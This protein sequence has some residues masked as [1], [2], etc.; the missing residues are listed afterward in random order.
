MNSK[1]VV[2]KPSLG[3][4]VLCV[5]ALVGCGEKS[6]NSPSVSSRQ[7]AKQTPVAKAPAG[8][9]AKA[10]DGT[11]DAT[12]DR[13][14]ASANDKKTEPVLALAGNAPEQS[15]ETSSGS[16]LE[17]QWS[18]FL[19]TASNHYGFNADQTA[20][21]RAIY[22]QTTSAAEARRRRYEAKGG[23]NAAAELKRDLSRLRDQFIDRIDSIA[24]AEQ[25]NKAAKEGFKSPRWREPPTP[26]EVGFKAPDWSLRDPQGKTV[27]LKGLNGKVVVLKFWGS[28]CG[29]CKS[30]LPGFQKLA[31]QYED[32]AD[33][34]VIGVS[35]E[36]GRGP[37]KA[38]DLV[39]KQKYTFDVLVNGEQ[40]AALYQV[41]GFPTLF[42][43]GPDGKILHKIRGANPNVEKI[44]TPIIDRALKKDAA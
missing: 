44:L 36:R 27:S 15:N 21:A 28:W 6:N 34:E 8:A 38:L 31:E 1:R 11:P 12:T 14:P 29:A 33:V 16:D 25:I 37:E 35:C 43:I 18:A 26:P 4:S 13:K 9:T 7:E 3:V 23:P 32:N 22:N 24:S 41:T 20:K 30:A 42:V 39:K 40:I 5:S 10:P 2:R 19:A 17:A